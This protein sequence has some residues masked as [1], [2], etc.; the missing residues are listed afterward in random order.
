MNFMTSTKLLTVLILRSLF[1]FDNENNTYLTNIT[2]F[3]QYNE[4]WGVAENIISHNLYTNLGFI[5]GYTV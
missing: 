3:K 2:S 5:S 1:D 4:K